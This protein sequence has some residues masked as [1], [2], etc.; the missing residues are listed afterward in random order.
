MIADSN[1]ELYFFPFFTIGIFYWMFSLFAFKMLTPFL[2]SPLEIPYPISPPLCFSADVPQATHPILTS[3]PGIPLQWGIQ[4]S[5]D[6]GPLLPLMP[7][8]AIIC[9]I[10]CWGHGYVHLYS[11]IC[12]LVPGSSVVVWL[13]D[14]VV[15][16][17]GLQTPSAPSSFL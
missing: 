10:C 1:T 3:C 11:L 13:V 6:Q 9:Y 7:N 14:I 15:L 17:V 12:G 16:P 8:K 2:L 5:Q 4:P